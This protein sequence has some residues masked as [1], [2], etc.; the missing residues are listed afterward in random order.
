MN[1]EALF[2]QNK[3]KS[4]TGRYITLESIEPLLK[5][6]NRN[7]EVQI[8]G[9]SVLEKPIYS[10]ESGKGKTKIFLWSQMHGNESTT[11]KALFDFINLLN[12]G[13]ELAK[14]LLNAF[15]FL[16]IPM[17][18][19]DGA[20]LYTRENA[21]KVDLNRDS[22]DLTQP[23]SRILRQAFEVF[24]PEYCFNLHDQRTIFGVS[25]TGKPATMSFLAPSYNEAREINDSRLKAINVIAAINDGLQ[26]Y[27]PNQVGRFD[28][29]FNINCIGDTFQ[30]LGVPTILF[31]AGHYQ[32]DYER[33]VT[34]KHAFMAFVFAFT[35]I[36]ENDIV[37][38]GIDKYMNIPQ[39]KVVFYDF[40]Y[41]NIRINYDGIEKI[42]NFAAQYK[43][44][45]ID[46]QICFNAY[47]S[48]IGDLENYFGHTEYDAQGALYKDEI[49]NIPILNQK[50]D[51][52]LTNNVEFV[53][54]MIKM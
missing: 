1:L 9:K 43:E 35:T 37:I 54:G 6:L 23:E 5:Q 22:Q 7:N 53:N 39:N 38:N 31:E 34:R 41:K 13:S 10:Y 3:E 49:N 15:T 30:Y 26:S 16:S 50:A 29:S 8:I 48:Q 40:I 21:N 11:T 33:E 12:S 2:S 24:K 14:Q 51:F 42:T 47:F 44:E 45:L 20:A 19:P 4:I 18:N 25:D 32:N 52:Y 27:M 36:S 28:D 17:L 46:N